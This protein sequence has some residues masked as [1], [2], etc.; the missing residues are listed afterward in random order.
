VRTAIGL[1]AALVIALGTLAGAAPRA[2]AA[3]FSNPVIA[4]NVADPSVVRADGAY[5]AAATSGHWAPVFPLYRST[6]LVHWDQVGAVFA[7]PP[8]WARGNFWAPGLAVDRGVWSVYYSASRRGG[9][10]CIAVAQAPRPYGPWRD[11]GFVICQ[12]TGSIDPAAVSDAAGQRY[13]VWK[14]MGVGSGIWG[15]RLSPS[16]R[17]LVSEPVRLTLPNESWEEGV[18]EGP[19]IVREGDTYVLVYSGGHCCRPPC[20]YAVGVARSQQV[21]G[22]YSKNPANPVFRGGNGWKCPGHGTL[23]AGPDGQLTFLHHAY[24]DD[25]A[26]DVHRQALLDPVVFG[27]DGW[28]AFGAAGVPV[29]AGPESER[30]TLRDAFA[31]RALA[32]GWQ[33]PYDGPPAVRVGGGRLNVRRGAVSRP[34]VPRDFAADVRVYGRGRLALLLT[35]GRVIAVSAGPRG[36]ALIDGPRTVAR[37]PLAATD[38]SLHVRAGRAVAAYARR[39]GGRRVRVGAPVLAREGLVVDRVALGPGVFGDVELRPLGRR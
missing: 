16:G 25:D 24:A 36:V 37:L 17:R 18:T 38:L 29:A 8:A 26:L 15:A 32:P 27:A 9:K 6:D 35:G 13:L 10:P 12:P 7:R 33:W 28:P 14:M 11:R 2:D 23:V 22:P 20:T 3:P 1:A 31:G 39:R 19:D 30:L 5:W 34:W 4:G 21:L